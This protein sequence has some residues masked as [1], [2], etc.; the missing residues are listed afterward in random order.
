MLDGK[1]GYGV[2]YLRMVSRDCAQKKGYIDNVRQRFGVESGDDSVAIAWTYVPTFTVQI[3]LFFINLFPFLSQIHK[4]GRR[5]P[6]MLILP[7]QAEHLYVI[8]ALT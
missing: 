8:F 5:Q 1:L 3:R 2:K 6:S 7:T 4:N